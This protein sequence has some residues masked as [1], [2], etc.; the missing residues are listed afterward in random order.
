VLGA[1]PLSAGGGLAGATGDLAGRAAF[2]APRHAACAAP[3]HALRAA[4]AASLP[5]AI[6]PAAGADEIGKSPY[7]RVD[8]IAQTEFKAAR[9][10]L[11]KAQ[12]DEAEERALVALSWTPFDSEAYR[13]LYDIATVRGDVPARLRWGKWLYWSYDYT[14]RDKEA[15][16]FAAEL[17]GVWEGWNADAEFLATWRKGFQR[18]IDRAM[19]KKQYRVAGYLMDKLM[20]LDQRDPD[21]RRSYDRLFDKA[22]ESLSGG[23]FVAARVRR[24]SPGWVDRQNEKHADWENAFKRK[25]RHYSIITNISYE[26]FETVSV[27]MEDMFA[28]YRLIYRYKGGAPK[29]TL[30]IHRKRSDFDKYCHE[31]L[32]WS[33]PTGVGGW[34]FDQEM[35]VAA[36]D[37]TE[38]EGSLTDLYRVLFHEASHQFM[39]LITQKKTKIDPPTWLNEGTA[40]YFE[41]CEL[42]SDGTIVKN[43]P[44]RGRVREWEMLEGGERGHTLEEVI[45]CPHREYDGSFYSY[46]WSLVYFLNNYENEAGDLVYRGAYLKYLDSYKKKSPKDPA[47]AAQ[48]AYDRAVKYFITEIKDPEVTDWEAFE[49]RWRKFTQNVVRETKAGPELADELQERCK[50]Y[51]QRG[52]FERA[53]IAATQADQKRPLD[54]ETYRLLALAFDGLDQDADALYW[55]LRHWEHMWVEGEEDAMSTAEGWMKERGGEEIVLGFCAANREAYERLGELVDSTVEEG[56]PAAA[57]LFASH[58][59]RAFGIDHPRILDRID[60]L[61]QEAGM[62]LRPWRKAFPHGPEANRSRAGREAVLYETDGVALFTPNRTYYKTVLVC[63]E[64]QLSTLTPPYQVRGVLRVDGDDGA[65]VMLGMTP[66]GRSRAQFNFMNGARVDLGTE[67]EMTN[68]DEDDFAAS[69]TW[70]SY[71]PVDTLPLSP[72]QHFEFEIEV[73]EETGRFMIEDEGTR[74]AMA[75]PRVFGEGATEGAFAVSAGYDT[76]ALFRDVEIRTSRPFWPVP[77]LEN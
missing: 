30:A 35:M 66:Q 48:E 18:T 45:R 4:P 16:A 40:S 13:L 1:S 60:E 37:R 25:T 72:R 46:G 7:P 41:G 23:D 38:G 57:M 32:G 34:F 3:A 69:F 49:G 51:L 39:Y 21:L 33:L 5:Y 58:A 76:A 71:V 17:D 73:F 2:L 70:W 55:M 53:Q 12:F 63:R 9:A 11:A 26:F 20:D 64:P 75:F 59:M 68:E 15:K 42:K 52:D 10:A 24:R 67:R 19:S 74:R 54:P 47:E 8:R 77:A 31:N 61:E 6:Q 27:V 56:Y 14:G 44:A 65:Y 36:Y 28:F 62:D 22:G 29:V 43:N 50:R